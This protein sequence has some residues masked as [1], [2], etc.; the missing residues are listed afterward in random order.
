MTITLDHGL[1]KSGCDNSSL[2]HLFWF[3]NEGN[4]KISQIEKEL[5]KV[6]MLWLATQKISRNKS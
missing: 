2:A 6:R 1:R 4:T 3:E 5:Y